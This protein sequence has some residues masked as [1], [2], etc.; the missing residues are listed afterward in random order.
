MGWVLRPRVLSSCKVEG[1]KQWTGFPSGPRCS[2]VICLL[3]TFRSSKAGTLWANWGHTLSWKKSWSTSR[4]PGS[5]SSSCGEIRL[6]LPGTQGQ[7]QTSLTRLI[8]PLS[9]QGRGTRDPN[10]DPKGAATSIT[11]LRQ[12]Q[13]PD[14]NNWSVSFLAS[15]PHLAYLSGATATQVVVA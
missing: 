5:G 12:L 10:S 1:E 13:K 2:S 3:V 7:T 11:V 8:N 9:R 14:S 4:F 15:R 6:I